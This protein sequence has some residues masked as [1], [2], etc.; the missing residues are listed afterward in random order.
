[1]VP[2]T[3]D[4]TLANPS[5]SVPEETEPSAETLVADAEPTLE[6]A[7]G[8]LDGAGVSWSESGTVDWNTPGSYEV[9][10]TGTGSWFTVTAPLTVVVTQ[11]SSG[12]FK[13]FN[14]SCT[15]L[16]EHDFVRTDCRD[17]LTVEQNIAGR[18]RFAHAAQP[19]QRSRINAFAWN[20]SSFFTPAMSRMRLP[21]KL[22]SIAS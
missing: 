18:G 11:P 1:M 21:A 3:P 7:N 9:T 12:T 14:S 17:D 5:V 2:E 4:V 16:D 13:V 19:P 6:F 20:M 10:L 8:V 15:H 22:R